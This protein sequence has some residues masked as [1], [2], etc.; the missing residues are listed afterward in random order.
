MKRIMSFL[1]VVTLSVVA[2]GGDDDDDTN[3]SAGTSTGAT[4]NA[5]EPAMSDGGE[6]AA[7]AG[8]APATGNVACD[9]E[10]DGVCQNP[11]D[12]PFVESGEAR[13][14]AG[15][16]GSSCL[17]GGGDDP[18]CPVN[19]MLVEMGLD[20]SSECATCYGDAAVCGIA[21]CAAD[22]LGMTESE[23]CQTCLVD[24]GCRSDFNSCSGLE[25]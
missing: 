3:G 19:C 13:M 1:A 5:G 14:V 8:G 11:M 16:C 10:V 2:C 21:N 9:P 25:Q 4:G 24:A 17:L 6:P 22:C 23:G 7:P 12:C 15:D 18:D 20:M